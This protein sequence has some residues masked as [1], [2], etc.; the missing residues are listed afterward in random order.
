V[1]TIQELFAL[2][3]LLFAV[4][5]RSVEPLTLGMRLRNRRW[6]VVVLASVFNGRKNL[7]LK[8]NAMG[9]IGLLGATRTERDARKTRKGKGESVDERGDGTRDRNDQPRLDA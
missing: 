7:L 3:V 5:T 2:L 9:A 8:E 6:R 1:K 4:L